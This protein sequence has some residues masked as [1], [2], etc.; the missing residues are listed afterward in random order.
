MYMT[1]LKIILMQY[2]SI[3]DKYTERRL[4]SAKPVIYETD[5]Y[6]VIELDTGEEEVIEGIEIYEQ[7]VKGL[8]LK[9]E[10]TMAYY[11]NELEETVYN[12]I[13]VH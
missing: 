12:E 9:Y 1:G 6:T 7:A 2:A 4:V 10:K 5:Y 13:Y 11:N 3:K 8:E